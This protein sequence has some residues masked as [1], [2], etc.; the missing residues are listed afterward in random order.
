MSQYI[1]LDDPLIDLKQ[2]HRDVITGTLSKL[3]YRSSLSLSH[4]RPPQYLKQKVSLRLRKEEDM[5]M[6]THELS[7]HHNYARLKHNLKVYARCKSMK[8]NKVFERQTVHVGAVGALGGAREDLG[9]L[10]YKS[11]KEDR[12]VF[13][14]RKYNREFAISSAMAVE[15]SSIAEEK[16]RMRKLLSEKTVSPLARQAKQQTEKGTV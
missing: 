12:T 2:A 13:I 16:V 6:T 15:M 8:L 14:D 1:S 7:L 3:L 9:R 11:D 10:S 5:A 4:A